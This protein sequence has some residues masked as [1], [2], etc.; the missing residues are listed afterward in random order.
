MGSNLVAGSGP[1]YAV[2]SGFDLTGMF[3]NKNLMQKLGISG[4]PQTLADLNADLAKAKAAGD[5]GLELAAEDGHGAFLVQQVADD[6]V[7]PAP[8]NNWI[9]GVKGSNFNLAGG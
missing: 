7:P 4:P 9:F 3:Y 8:V 2:S 1:L 5:I 6:Y